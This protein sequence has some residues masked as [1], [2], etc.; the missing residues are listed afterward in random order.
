MTD[1]TF[2]TNDEDLTNISSKNSMSI[3]INGSVC[4]YNTKFIFCQ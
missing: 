2:N 4:D 3:D 1:I